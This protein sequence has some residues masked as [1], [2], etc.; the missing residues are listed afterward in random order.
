MCIRDR[1]YIV[2]SPRMRSYSYEVLSKVKKVEKLYFSVLSSATIETLL[3]PFG[4]ISN[5]FERNALHKSDYPLS[6]PRAS[7]TII[8]C[9]KL[10]VKST[11]TVSRESDNADRTDHR[12][13]QYRRHNEQYIITK[14][15]QWKQMKTEDSKININI[16]IM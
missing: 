6:E 15:P 13:I 5:A 10:P 1:Y 7:E 16:N 12:Q 4:A 14:L 3:I 9:K 2:S 8:H 11:G